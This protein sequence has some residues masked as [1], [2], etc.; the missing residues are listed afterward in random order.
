MELL[1]LYNH[2]M[3]YE[4]F[5]SLL[6]T[7][8][9][10]PRIVR[11]YEQLGLHL[12]DAARPLDPGLEQQSIAVGDVA[13]LFRI[14][15]LAVDPDSLPITPL[16]VRLAQAIAERP[17]PFAVAITV[18]DLPATLAE[19]TGRGVTP[20]SQGTWREGDKVVGKVALLAEEE[21]AATD[22]LLVQY[23]TSAKTRKGPTHNLP[24]RRL[25]HL[26]AV[27]ADLEAQTRFWVDVLGVPLFGQVRTSSLVIH[28]F[29]IGDAILELLG[30]AT[31]DSPIARR[32][33]GLIAMASWEVADLEKAVAQVHAAGFTITDPAPGALPGTETATVGADE[34]GGLTL[35]LL[36][37]IR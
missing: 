31:P 29:K 11:L 8:P 20:R 24:I 33:P 34:L 2:R 10:L 5:D 3:R 6:L 25:D 15:F 21:R 37:Y 35:Q 13:N 12:S 26:A 7:V 30:P 4:K 19:L 22:I 1:P 16:G 32:P 27:A 17:G 23:Q 9:S 14:E 18:P 28:Q 36:Q